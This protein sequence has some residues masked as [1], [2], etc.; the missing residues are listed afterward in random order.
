MS[1]YEVKSQNTNAKVFGLALLMLALPQV[2]MAQDLFGT[3][4]TFIDNVLDFL[5][6]G[7]ARSIAIIAVIGLGLS[8]VFGKFELKKAL[9]AIFG[10]ILIFG[11]AALV[12][13]ISTSI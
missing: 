6:G 1:K 9:W 8:A 11:A 5:N 7:F 13:G 3:G 4:G 12:D 10:I 2:A